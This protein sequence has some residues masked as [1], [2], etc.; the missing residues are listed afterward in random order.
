M[1]P[2]KDMPMTISAKCTTTILTLLACAS[3]NA[4]PVAAR[5]ADTGSP[6]D[7]AVEN[8]DYAAGRRAV[9]RKDWA[10]ATES[11]RKAVAAEPNNADALNML[12][13][14]YRWQG[15]LDEAFANYERALAINPNHRGALEYQGVAFVKTGQLAKAEANL[16]RLEKISGRNGEEYRDLAKAIADARAAK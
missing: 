5:A 1:Q 11:F 4:L 3:L 2:S 6:P 14:S 12:A 7:Q 13:Y 10:A 16:A 8:R 9:A 15:K